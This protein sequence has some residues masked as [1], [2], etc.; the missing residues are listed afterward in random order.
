[1]KF[2]KPFTKDLVAGEEEGG[3]PNK[4]VMKSMKRKNVNNISTKQMKSFRALLETLSRKPNA[5][6]I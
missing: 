2:S 1:M 4:G 6:L 3:R 5:R